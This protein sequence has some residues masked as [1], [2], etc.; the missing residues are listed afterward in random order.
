MDRMTLERVNG[1]KTGYWSPNK[2]E[3][4]VQRLAAYENTGLEPIQ[5]QEMKKK[6][7]DQSSENNDGW[8]PVEERMPECNKTVLICQR[9]GAIDVAW[10]DGYRWK[11]GFSQADWL[12][13]VVAWRPLPEPYG[14]KG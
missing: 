4:L 2:K 13:D 6:I 3:E 1:I 10:N 9:R 7:F 14:P 8:I 5:I 12:T 11:T